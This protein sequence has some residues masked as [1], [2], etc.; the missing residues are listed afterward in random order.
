MGNQQ[1]H[2][3]SSD[4]LNDADQFINELRLTAITTFIAA[5][6]LRYSFFG[7]IYRIPTQMEQ[8]G[9]DITVLQTTSEKTIT[10]VTEI[11]KILAAKDDV[12]AEVGRSKLRIEAL[13]RMEINR[14]NMQ[15]Q[16]NNLEAVTKEL[17]KLLDS[18]SLR[19]SELNINVSA[20]KETAIETK[21]ALEELKRK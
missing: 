21:R 18:T 5:L 7:N 13:E 1:K 4:E 2:Q 17:A 12:F 8:H 14:Q 11:E 20:L 15:V 10:R 6:M 9:K 16:I 3:P 19:L